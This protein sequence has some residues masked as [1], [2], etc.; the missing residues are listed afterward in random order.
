MPE[1]AVKTEGVNSASLHPSASRLDAAQW[2]I[3]SVATIGALLSQLDATIVNVS[4]SSLAAE[5]QTSLATIQWVTSGY[6]LTL[7]LVLPMSGWLVD[8]VGAKRVYLWC[9]LAFTLASALCGMAWSATSLIGFRVLQGV[10]GGLLA[11]MAQMIIARAAGAQMA[12]V[13][14]Y[15]AVPVLAAPILGPVLAGAILQHASWRWLF[16]LNLPIGVLAFVLAWRFLPHDQAETRPREL[17]WLGL[18]LLSPALVLFLSG[19]TR[20]GEPIGWIRLSG[21]I[22]LLAGFLCVERRKRERALLDLHLFRGKVFGAAALTQFFSNGAIF[23]GQALV[24]MF[25]IDACGR[26]PG[27]MGWMLMPMGLGMLVT[28]PLMGALTARFGVRKLAQGGALL[29]LVGTL[30]FVWLARYGL[31]PYVLAPALFLRGMGLSAIG[32]P[33]ISAAYASVER[34]HLPMATTTMNIVQRLGGPTWTTLC[35]VLLARQLKGQV[36]AAQWMPG[37]Y[38]WAF[39]ALCALHGLTCV[40]TRRLPL[41]LLPVD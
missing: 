8:R 13:I 34:A 15:M 37:P 33:S 41:A 40:A 5:L 19:C 9:F 31:Q 23:A 38:A 6:L 25:L 18:A 4:L 2:K 27:E 11:P 24:P 32:A 3:I 35:T 39:T 28:Y 10:C 14:G 20:V 21:S 26:S 36:H 16:L 30:P 1:G 12:R 17:D 7:T 29:A 22:A